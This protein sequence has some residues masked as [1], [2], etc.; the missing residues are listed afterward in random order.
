MFTPRLAIS[1]SATILRISHVCVW[2]MSIFLE[3]SIHRCAARW[4]WA[5]ESALSSPSTLSS[6]RQYGQSQSG[7][8]AGRAYIIPCSCRSSWQCL[9]LYT[10]SSCSRTTVEGREGLYPRRHWLKIKEVRSRYSDLQNRLRPSRIERVRSMD[11]HFAT[12]VSLRHN[13]LKESRVNQN[14]IS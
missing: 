3:H 5:Q 9:P 11:H 7:I 4:S 14:E 2:R 10:P 8:G 1:H 6:R 13:F 12:F